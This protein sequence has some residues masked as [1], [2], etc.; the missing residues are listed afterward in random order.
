MRVRLPPIPQL[1]KMKHII[2]FNLPED[3]ELLDIHIRACKNE[4]ALDE[5]VAL[6]RNRIKYE[7]LSKQA[8]KEAEVIF[9]RVIEI[10]N[11][12]Y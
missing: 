4:W 2:E 5:I 7:N 11:N 9:N 3:Q 12:R 6:L 8:L 10:V 1:I